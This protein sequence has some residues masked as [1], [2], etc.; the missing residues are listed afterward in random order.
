MTMQELLENRQTAKLTDAFTLFNELSKNLSD[1]YQAL[2]QQVAGLNKEL[3]AARTQER[4]TLIEKEKLVSRLQHILAALPAAVVVLNA[5]NQV[6]DCN[7]LANEYLGKSLIGQNWFDVSQRSLMNVFDNPHERQL[8]NGIRVSMT[9]SQMSNKAGQVILLSDVSQMRAMQEQLNQQQHLSA[10][11]EMVASMAHQ[12]RTPLSTA[13]LYASQ[14]NQTNVSEAKRITF[15]NKILERLHYLERQV[16]DMLIYAKE[17]RLSMQRFSLS[18]LLELIQEQMALN[19]KPLQL[20]FNLYN[21]C[22][23]D[24]MLGNEDALGGAL[25]NLLNNA[26]EASSAAGEICMT[27]VQVDTTALKITISD[28]GNGID[29][30]SQQRLFEPFY[31]TKVKGSGLGLAVVDSVIRAHS[32]SI[33]CISKPG[34]GTKFVLLLPCVNQYVTNLSDSSSFKMEKNDESL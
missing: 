1:S 19:C 13:I 25:M 31:T 26:V 12:V 20:S 8:T 34:Q 23:V 9:S 24:E 17:G 27:V 30:A 22:K 14:M 10:M 18:A 32:G 28:Q 15:A 4:K 7:L 16:N 21:Q 11:G 29:E 3:L 5:E 33:R 2:Q 6:I